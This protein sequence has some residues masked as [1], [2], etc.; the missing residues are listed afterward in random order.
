MPKKRDP[1]RIPKKELSMI[2]SFRRGQQSKWVGVLILVVNG[3]CVSL[4]EPVAFAHETDDSHP[5]YRELEH[6][7][8]QQAEL[9]NELRE[10]K[11]LLQARGIAAMPQL[12]ELRLG[13]GQEPF[14][15]KHDVRLTLIEFTDYQCPFCRRHA[16]QTLPE[17]EREYIE[18][19]K[20]KYVVRDFPLQSLH[21]EAFQAAIAA[22]CAGEQGR[23]WDMHDRLLTVD[24]SNDRNWG[25][26]A[27]AVGLDEGKFLSCLVSESPRE[28][29]QK[30]LKEGKKAGVQGTP[31]FFLGMT[32]PDSGEMKV[33]K[34]LRGAQSY[35]KMKSSI[36]ELL[37]MP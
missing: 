27:K 36:D 2:Q 12:G 34:V 35:A 14:K 6:L 30:D 1:Q 17:L 15:G 13:V 33:V 16:K 18:T 32:E 10:I 24:L 3:L 26:H 31:T 25:Q 20:L 9:R 11:A 37:G 21:R 7:K 22:D 8:A 4:L 29:V 19:E 5:V 28:G 23:Y